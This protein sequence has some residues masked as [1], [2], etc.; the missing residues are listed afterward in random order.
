VLG[1]V[2]NSQNFQV[3]TNFTMLN[4]DWQE[5]IIKNEQS[6]AKFLLDFLP[7]LVLNG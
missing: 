6:L 5:V 4:D 3:F 7:V 1:N 2:N